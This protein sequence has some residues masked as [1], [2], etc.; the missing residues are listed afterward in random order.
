MKN[1]K[2]EDAADITQIDPIPEGVHRPIWS[3][4]IPTYNRTKYLEEVLRSVLEQAPEPEL[5]QIE[6]IDN[7]STEADPE[8]VVRRIGQGR[9]SFFKQSKNL[10]LKGNLITCIERSRGHLVHILHD[11]DAVLPEF[12]SKLQAAFEQEPTIGAAFCRWMEVDETSRHRYI[13]P[14]KRN[15][16]GILSNWLE[17]IA[18]GNQ[19]QAPAI[20]VRRSVYEA[21]GA[22]H[23]KLEHTVD[24]EMWK[25]IAAHYPVWYEPQALAHYR[26]HSSSDTSDLIR[27][28]ANIVDTRKAIEI[29]HS[30]LPT[31]IAGK[32]SSRA[33][34]SCALYALKIARRALVRGDQKAGVNQIREALKC[35]CSFKVISTLA[36]LPLMLGLCSL[37]K[38]MSETKEE[39][40]SQVKMLSPGA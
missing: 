3:V 16:P 21:L 22:F 36:L 4:M 1:L 6:V 29:S 38:L 27:S 33:R 34:E 20:V 28:G 13:A 11:D 25:R 10:G 17:R 26:V 7:C 8:A 19:I 31:Q 14:L 37:K 30:Y 2:L 12:Y 35:S 9:V 24:W 18:V 40:V 15:T 23:P 5:M 39:Q 32:L